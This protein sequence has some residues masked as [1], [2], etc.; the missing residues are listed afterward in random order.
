MLNIYSRSAKPTVNWK[1]K[2]KKTGVD[3]KKKREK[4]RGIKSYTV[5][6]NLQNN[7][8]ILGLLLDK[9]AAI[10]EVKTLCFFFLGEG[11]GERICMRKELRDH[12][13]IRGWGAGA[14]RGWIS[15]FYA[16]IQGG[17]QKFTLVY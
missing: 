11:R 1:K 13:I 6:T 17:L 16:R 7:G 3:E 8:L 10:L 4:E 2:K 15:K 14:D 9:K 12:S 5:K